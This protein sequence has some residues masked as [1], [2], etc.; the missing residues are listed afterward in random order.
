MFLWFLF[1]FSS[2]GAVYGV[3][4]ILRYNSQGRVQGRGFGFDRATQPVA[5]T[6][7]MTFNCVVVILLI[8]AACVMG[9]FL[10]RH[11]ISGS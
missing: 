7:L 10:L 3:Y 6:V 9:F 2:L 11:V 8:I 4:A 1:A 5:F